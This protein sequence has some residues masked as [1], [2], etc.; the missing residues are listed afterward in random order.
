[1][2]SGLQPTDPTLSFSNDLLNEGR[3]NSLLASPDFLANPSCTSTPTTIMITGYNI[4]P[5]P[6]LCPV[7][8]GLQH[9]H[10][11][12]NSNVENY[13]NGWAH[14]AKWWKKD[15][16]TRVS[17]KETTGKGRKSTTWE[18]GCCRQ[19]YWRVTL[20]HVAGIWSQLWQQHSKAR[21]TDSEE[22]WLALTDFTQ[23]RQGW[24][25]WRMIQMSVSGQVSH[26]SWGAGQVTDWPCH[27]EKAVGES[28]WLVIMSWELS[29]QHGLLPTVPYLALVWTKD[30]NRQGLGLYCM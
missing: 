10:F 7:Y 12:S 14:T 26:L 6:L 3:S 5:A 8:L 15:D 13:S 4:L 28:W 19:S 18:F 23:E 21:S 17:K 22:E 2:F 20:L 16:E 29:F 25:S 9:R 30:I 27:A 24:W 11:S 1:M